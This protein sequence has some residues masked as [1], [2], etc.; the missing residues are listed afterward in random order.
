MKKTNTGS[1]GFRARL[2]PLAALA[3]PAL[4][5]LFIAGC[6]NLVDMGGGGGNR[7]DPRRAYLNDPA[8]NDSLAT[9]VAGRGLVFVLQPG[10]E[11][12]LR[13]RKA[14][15]EGDRLD[16]YHRTGSG[17]LLHQSVAG[18]RQ[19]DLLTF[20]LSPTR[21]SADYYIAFMRTA[22]GERASRAD[23]G[24]RLVAL[25][26]AGSTTLA[27]RLLMVRQLQ[28]LSSA[29]AKSLYARNFNMELRSVFAAYGITVD[30]STLVVEPEAAPLTVD[31]AKSVIDIPGERRHG[32]INIYLVDSIR[33]G[34]VE[35]TILG[36]AP[37]EAFDLSGDPESR[38]ILNV[39]GGGAVAMAVT[40]AHEI[41]HF[42][43]LRHTTATLVDREYD[44][45]ESNRNDGFATTEFCQALEK[46]AAGRGDAIIRVRG[47]RPYCLRTTGAAFTCTCPDV[48][49]LMYPYGCNSSTQKTLGADQQGFLRNNLR[50]FQ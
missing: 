6:G 39:R 32:A 8:R 44:D 48:G 12:A 9:A 47:G 38:V 1:R 2:F 34:D 50:V 22:G 42:L 19:G 41:G 4:S 46:P 25:D 37:R 10:E 15:D 35:G 3:L 45:D 29:S 27:V 21:S 11:Y 24:V 16:F 18:E 31:F 49:N 40:A 5:A 36:F 7:V 28:G 14:Q 33:A 17:F 26:T 13:M 20:A 43:G 30:T 23:S